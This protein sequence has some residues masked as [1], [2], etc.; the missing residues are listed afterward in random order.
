MTSSSK[1]RLFPN[2]PPPAG[3]KPASAYTRFIP[4]EEVGSYERFKLGDIEQAERRSHPRANNAPPT[5][6][7]WRAMLA[8]ARSKAYQEGYRDGMSALESFKASYAQQTSARLGE[9]LEAF[10]AQLQAMETRM[11]ECVARTS[12]LL[13][14]QVLRQELEVRPEAVAELAR[15]AVSTIQAGVRHVV[16]RVHP[17]DLPLVHAGAAEA[18]QA[19]GATL[20][21]DPAVRRGGCAID[22]EA[23]SIDATLERR[24]R[25]ATMQ[26]GVQ[27]PWAPVGPVAAQAA[28]D[29][30][31]PA[32]AGPDDAAG[33]APEGVSA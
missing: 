18:L 26:L 23:D 21:P 28:A 22:S 7:E 27:V 9:L 29:A 16:V 24:W 17:E 1:S 13:A 15:E 20:Q 6:E 4:R 19:R 8:E 31:V 14:R 10:D 5:A 33:L 30:G 25:Q 11:A 12:V 32:A 2:I 3:T